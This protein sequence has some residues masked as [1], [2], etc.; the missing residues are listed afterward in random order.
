[1]WSFASVHLPVS[2]HLDKTSNHFELRGLRMNVNICSLLF[3]Y[4]GGLNLGKK[5]EVCML[6]VSGINGGKSL[7]AHIVIVHIPFI[8]TIHCKYVV[9]FCIK[10][11]CA[12]FFQYIWAFI[13]YHTGGSRLSRTAVKP[14]SRLARIFVAKFLCIIK[15]IIITG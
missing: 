8:L 14:D 6:Y 5:N 3:G 1:M 7:E 13:T 10:S 12:M 15:L 4:L 11:I 9:L 2:M